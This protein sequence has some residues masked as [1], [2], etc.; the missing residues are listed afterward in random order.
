[1]RSSN[2]ENN[3]RKLVGNETNEQKILGKVSV[4]R[5]YGTRGYLHESNTCICITG[6]VLQFQLAINN[7]VAFCYNS[8]SS[9]KTLDFYEFCMSSPPS[10][11]H[12]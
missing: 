3:S 5:K 7:T 8:L 10:P 2:G 12:C 4:S 1:M 11:K 9:K 6:L